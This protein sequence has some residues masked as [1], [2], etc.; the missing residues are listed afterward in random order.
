MTAFETAL[1]FEIELGA[2]RATGTET[3]ET[4]GIGIAGPAAIAPAP[5]ARGGEELR[6]DL[7][8]DFEIGAYG[9]PSE[10]G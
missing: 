6:V 9:R 7:P 3:L 4:A 10:K 2:M 1:E 8:T 5:V